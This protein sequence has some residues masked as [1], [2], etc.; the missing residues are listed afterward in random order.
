MSGFEVDSADLAVVGDR[1][2]AIATELQQALQ[3]RA[4]ASSQFGSRAVEQS[5]RDFVNAWDEGSQ[6]VAEKAQKLA[7]L[8]AVAGQTYAEHD[9]QMM[10]SFSGF[11]TFDSGNGPAASAGAA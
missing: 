9:A 5:L 10:M 6:K 11:L 2:G 4:A 8:T 3:F 7:R 1:V